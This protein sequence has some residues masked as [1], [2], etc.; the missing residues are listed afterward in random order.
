VDERARVFRGKVG[1]DIRD[2]GRFN[3]ERLESHG[4]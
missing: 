2:S 4:T 3:V 1:V